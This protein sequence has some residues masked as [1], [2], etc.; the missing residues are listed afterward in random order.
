MRIFLKIT[1]IIASIV[2]ALIVLFSI[3]WV[4]FFDANTLKP[5]VSRRFH[6]LTGREVIF[7][8]NLEI[9][10][11]P[12]VGF[13][14]QNVVIK[15]IKGFDS[16]QPY[17]KAKEADI[18]VYLLP[19][20]IRNKVNW[21]LPGIEGKPK[22][23]ASDKKTK[24]KFSG[25]KI[26]AKNITINWK[27]LKKRKSGRISNIN[28]I[29]NKIVRQS[30]FPI[31]FTFSAFNQNTKRTTNFS[32]K[33]QIKINRSKRQYS[34]K[35]IQLEIDSGKKPKIKRPTLKFIGNFK[36]NPDG[37]H[38]EKSQLIK[39]GDILHIDN[40]EVSGLEDV[41]DFRFTN[42]VKNAKVS[43][44]LYSKQFKIKNTTIYDL[45]AKARS[46]NRVIQ[47]Y[48]LKAQVF[49]G[50]LNGKLTLDARKD[51]LYS[52]LNGSL[53]NFDLKS[54]LEAFYQVKNISGTANFSA[55]L[56]ARGAS[57]KQIRQSLSG[58][59]DAKVNNGVMS[60]INLEKMIRT[61]RS[62]LSLSL[63]PLT[64]GSNQTRFKNSAATLQI[65]NGI[66]TNKDLK[67]ESKNLVIQ[68]AGTANLVKKTLNYKLET[69]LKA[70]FWEG[71][72]LVPIN[73][74]GSFANPNVGLDKFSLLHEVSKNIMPRNI[75]LRGI[76]IILT[77]FRLIFGGSTPTNTKQK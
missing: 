54:F 35:D 13:K 10:I 42:L 38:V 63:A 39:N 1:V 46:R 12:S 28:F 23:S 21:A 67:M 70:D 36:I 74:T 30:F 5:Q 77:P 56:S 47:L 72:W 68:G 32:L 60:G 25:K 48:P 69:K 17:V 11:F 41:V 34:L 4:F 20:L 50:K 8:G 26:V 16:K 2:A 57:I 53:S 66:V 76:K 64:E 27:N 14:V 59:V 6:K 43:A 31:E 22:E 15:N 65:N 51:A 24:H 49:S 58:N 40:L 55:N 37:I 7:H 33:S 52:R 18:K 45:V 75:L 62:L 61:A 3:Y 9:S 44:D 73:I 19:L 71:D 29:A